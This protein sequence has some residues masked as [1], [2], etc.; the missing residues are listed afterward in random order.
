MVA[1]KP[2]ILLITGSWVLPSMYDPLVE[3]LR[4]AGYE[5]HVTSHKTNSPT[6]SQP[7]TTPY[8]DVPAIRELATTLADDGKDIVFVMHS[9]GGLPGSIACKGLGKAERQRTG[10]KGGVARLFFMTAWVPVEGKP[11]FETVPAGLYPCVKEFPVK[12]IIEDGWVRLDFEGRYDWFFEDVPVEDCRRYAAQMTYSSSIQGATPI[13]EV[14]YKDIPVSYLVAE[15]DNAFVPALQ[16]HWIELLKAHT[17]Q[18]VDVHS[19][20]VPHIFM[21]GKLENVDSVVNVIKKVAGE[22]AG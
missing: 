20:P 2:V 10:K 16:H 6:A 4:V 17:E 1:Q 8:D 11:G 15:H 18:E 13:S 12:H 21:Y 14:G 3:P 7:L 5:V 22:D 19:L 9:Y